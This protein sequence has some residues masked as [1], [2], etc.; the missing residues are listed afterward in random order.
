MPSSNGLDEETQ[1]KKGKLTKRKGDMAEFIAGAYFR[2]CG[3]YVFPK[4]SGPGDMFLLHEETSERHIIDV[5]TFN[6]RKNT[7]TGGRRINRSVKKEHKKHNIEI[8]YVKMDEALIKSI[9]N[10]IEFPY[11][12]GKAEW[13]KEFR[14]GHNE[15]G[16]YNGKVINR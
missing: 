4:T 14:M 15:K 12:K 8:V 1:K 16:Q 9:E 3:Y 6:D 13:D 2:N 10:S 5:K 11:G 7:K